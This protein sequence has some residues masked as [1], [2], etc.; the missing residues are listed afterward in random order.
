MKREELMEQSTLKER[1]PNE[2]EYCG[3]DIEKDTRFCKSEDR[4]CREEWNW[5]FSEHQRKVW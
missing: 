4:S 2:C 1:S 3:E 5:E